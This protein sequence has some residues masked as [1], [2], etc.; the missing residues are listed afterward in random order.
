[1]LNYGERVGDHVSSGKQQTESIVAWGE[2]GDWK[3]ASAWIGIYGIGWRENRRR[4]DRDS[5]KARSASEALRLETFLRK[6][7][8]RVSCKGK[9]TERRDMQIGTWLNWTAGG[10]LATAR[11]RCGHFRNGVERENTTGW[12]E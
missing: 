3:S 11:R 2:K 5:L 8:K 6:H 10:R 12:E 7:K 4:G 1:M 9:R